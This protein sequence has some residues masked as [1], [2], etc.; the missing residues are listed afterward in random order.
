MPLPR[1]EFWRDSQLIIQLCP[2]KIT[3]G[4]PSRLAL[5]CEEIP[6]FSAVAFS[7]DGIVVSVLSLTVKIETGTFL[8]HIISIVCSGNLWR[9]F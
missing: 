6:M 8:I 4:N 5:R 2:K 7:F 9:V 3:K 1:C